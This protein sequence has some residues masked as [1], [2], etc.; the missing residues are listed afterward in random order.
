MLKTT[1]TLRFNYEFS[2]IYKRGKFSTGRHLA[3][4]AFKRGPNLKH[5]LTRIPQDLLRVGFTNS[6][7][8]KTAVARNRAK[9]LLRAA[10]AKY[11]PDV[12][13]G[14]D[15]IF[16]MK[17]GEILPTYQEVEKEMGRHLSNL[18]LLKSGELL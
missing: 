15:I 6:H 7:G 13:L 3:V 12:L 11:E 4:H 1:Q 18:G 14:Y 17:S 2:R 9:R 8:R 10:F 5:N 16:L